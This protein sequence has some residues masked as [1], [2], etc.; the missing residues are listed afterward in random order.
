MEGQTGLFV[1][2]EVNWEKK[3]AEV[4]QLPE[5]S[6]GKYIKIFL[7]HFWKRLHLPYWI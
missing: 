2:R 1:L 5:R 3:A 6:E 7:S 4:E